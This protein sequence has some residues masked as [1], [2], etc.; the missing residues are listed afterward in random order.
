[1]EVGVEKALESVFWDE[2]AFVERGGLFEWT[3]PED[4]AGEKGG[5]GGAGGADLDW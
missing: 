5:C 3:K 2:D 4:D 1:L